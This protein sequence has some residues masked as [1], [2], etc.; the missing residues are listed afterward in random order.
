MIISIILIIIQ[1][2]IIQF[3]L[4]YKNITTNIN[5]LKFNLHFFKNDGTIPYY[6]T[7]FYIEGDETCEYFPNAFCYFIINIIIELQNLTFVHISLDN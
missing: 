6:Y 3:I 7:N 4:I 1:M 5:K 2:I